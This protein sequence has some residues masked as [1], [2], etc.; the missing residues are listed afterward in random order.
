MGLNIMIWHKKKIIEHPYWD[1]IRR[2]NDSDF[3]HKIMCNNDDYCFDINLTRKNLEKW[4]IDEP[5]NRWFNFLHI[6]EQ[7]QEYEYSISY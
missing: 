7:E 3:V 4:K 5:K 6:L 1:S 2:S